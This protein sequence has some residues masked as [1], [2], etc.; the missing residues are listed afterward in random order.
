[1]ALRLGVFL[2][3]I[4]VAASACAETC[5]SVEFSSGAAIVYPPIA[6]ATRTP[7]SVKVALHL[8][9]EAHIVSTE[10]LSSSSQL[11]NQQSQ[12]NAKILLFHFSTAGVHTP[13]DQQVEFDYQILP[14]EAESGFLRITF[15]NA[16]RVLIEAK[17][18]TPT[19]NY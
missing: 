16:S 18:H 17:L 3:L 13:C 10:I 7:G 15:D 12:I 5:K 19:V 9:G 4:L 11:L 2:A 6:L 8:D 1:M 14:G